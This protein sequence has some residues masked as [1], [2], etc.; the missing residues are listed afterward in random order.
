MAPPLR[1]VPVASQQE[2]QP[3]GSG[4]K[5]RAEQQPG[6]QSEL[7]RREA[8]ELRPFPRRGESGGAVRDD[9]DQIGADRRADV[10]SSGEHRVEPRSGE[11]KLPAGRDY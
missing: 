5:E 1:P 10:T 4:R 2:Q 3:E 11:R 7:F 6:T 9:S 8:V